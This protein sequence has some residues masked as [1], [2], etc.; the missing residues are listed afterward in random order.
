MWPNRWRPQ[1]TMLASMQVWNFDFLNATQGQVY[2][3]ASAT[4]ETLEPEE[5]NSV[6]LGIL[7]QASINNINPTNITVNGQQCTLQLVNNIT[8]RA[9]GTKVFVNMIDI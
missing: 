9:P 6:Y 5:A 7:L 8:G 1:P 2:G 3:N 4:Y